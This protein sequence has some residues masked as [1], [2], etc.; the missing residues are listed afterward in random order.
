MIRAVIL[1]LF[2]LTAACSHIRVERDETAKVSP[3][4]THKISSFLFALIP[5]RQLPPPNVLCPDSRIETLDLRMSPVDVL[6][7]SATLGIYV[8]HR[9]TVVCANLATP[10]P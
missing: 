2:L 10:T 1:L 7:T 5:G 6:V 4:K 9:V 3:A 8:P